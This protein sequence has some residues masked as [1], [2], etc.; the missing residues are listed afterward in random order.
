M[1]QLLTPR[2]PVVVG[3]T[4]GAVALTTTAVTDLVT[5][6]PTLDG[7][8]TVSVAGLVQTAAT[9]LTV[10][11]AYTDPITGKSETATLV[12]GVSES[13]GP[14]QVVGAVYAQGGSAVTVAAAAGT[15]NQVAL[16]ATVTAQP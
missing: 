14:V 9:D 16:A 10:T 1:A 12:N 11:V 6:T 13:V 3:R 4:V 7:L 8:L 15:A 2:E 5:V